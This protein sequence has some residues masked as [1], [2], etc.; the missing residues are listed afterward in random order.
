MSGRSL[1]YLE[2]LFCKGQMWVTFKSHREI[3]QYRFLL[4][5]ERDVGETNYWLRGLLIPDQVTCDHM[6]LLGCSNLTSEGWWKEGG[7]S[8]PEQGSEF[9][10]TLF[11]IPAGL[12]SPGSLVCDLLTSLEWLSLTKRFIEKSY[13]HPPLKH[14]LILCFCWREVVCLLT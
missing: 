12:L 13:S 2:A 6:A 14:L 7:A 10:L 11:P 3:Q 8:F 1:P 5:Y 9:K 4:Y